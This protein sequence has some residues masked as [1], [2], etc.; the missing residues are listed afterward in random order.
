MCG[1]IAGP[2][3]SMFVE[4][5]AA[6]G[7]RGPHSHGWA[8]IDAAGPVR[9]VGRGR[10]TAAT[11]PPA[12]ASAAWVIGHS[13]LATD[14]ARHGALPV[15]DEGQ[16]LIDG[17]VIVAHNGHAATLVDKGR[18]PSDSRAVAR[19][20]ATS[21]DLFNSCAEPDPQAAVFITGNQLYAWRHDGRKYPA[22]PL[23]LQSG[24]IVTSVPT[25]GSAVLLPVGLTC[26]S[27]RGNSW[28][29]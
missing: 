8:W 13:R 21:L 22:H 1:L 3:G 17:S 12:S 23:Y 18:P 29:R 10:L 25:H 9:V 24:S 26:I 14:T 2:G 20:A 5:A 27:E 6:A 28:P 4:A 11:L 19:W 15:P 7:R 16:P